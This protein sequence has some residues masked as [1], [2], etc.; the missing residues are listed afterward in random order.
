MNF[1]IYWP[2]ESLLIDAGFK[3]IARVPCI[4]N[5]N[6]NYQREASWYLRDR[7]R[8]E[9]L[10]LGEQ[11]RYPTK[12]SLETFG[13]AI[14]NFL[15]WCV[16]SS[17]PWQ[18]VDYFNDLI[19]GYQ[20]H[21]ESGVFSIRKK[22][23]SASTI[24]SRIDETCNFLKWA[25]RKG[26]RGSF[27]VQVQNM[28][29]RLPSRG[30]GNAY[31]K[32]GIS[33]VGQVRADPLVLKIPS[34][35][36]VERWL[37]CVKLEKGETKAL[38]CEIIIKTAIRRE[39]CVQWRIWT[40]PEDR[41]SWDIV[42]D[43]ITLKVEYGAKGSKRLDGDGVEV[44]PSRQIVIPLELAE[45]IHYYR[46]YVRPKIRMK[47]V[48]AAS[49]ET[50]RRQRMRN[51]EKRLFLSEYDGE[52]IS[53]KMLWK[54][55]SEVSI[56]PYREWSPHLGRHFWCCRTLLNFYLERQK[57]LAKGVVITGDWITG[58]AQSDLLT[59][60][61]PQLGHLDVKTTN[62]YLRWLQRLALGARYTDEWIENL[63]DLDALFGDNFG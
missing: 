11:T 55:W 15:E 62:T 41:R 16:W 52:P 38:M 1:L 19:N 57:Q 20:K 58:N 13:R 50:E 26:L 24:N 56:K 29:L 7:S 33:R 43:K 23:L 44:G 10:N 21:M 34:D 22:P 18:E 61:K 39:E 3:S 25:A 28:N 31:L 48:N 5:E 14:C 32:E 46:E 63:E 49:N 12:Q 45:R 8:G 60:I 17:R 36:E 54:A 6:W 37:D 35:E 53:G 9:A 27:K 2:E 59:I 40:L 47:F 4:F 42:G 30:V 51:I